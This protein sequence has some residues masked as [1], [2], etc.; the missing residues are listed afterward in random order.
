MFEPLGEFSRRHVVYR[1]Y[2]NW[3][4]GELIPYDDMP[5][6]LEIVRTL[7]HPVAK[8]FER[9]QQR[10]VVCI[11]G[12]GWKI[13]SGPDQV[14]VAI[15]HQRKATKTQGRALQIIET[16]DRREM[17]GEDQRRTDDKLINIRMGYG[18]LRGLASKKLGVEDV[19]RLQGGAEA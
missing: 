19:K 10:T 11:R 6:P 8:L 17:S 18:L 16:T 15:F 5:Y 13:V 3:K 12:E 7:R 1:K 14:D 2:S 4:T 9:E